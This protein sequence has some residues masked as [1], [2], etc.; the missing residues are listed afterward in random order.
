[1]RIEPVTANALADDATTLVEPLARASGLRLVIT[2]LPDD[3]ALATDS[4]K[5]RQI[6]V[7]LLSNAVKFTP[8]GEVSLRVTHNGTV[9][10]Y[11]VRDTGIGIA[12]EH[13][14]HIFEAFWQVERPST[15]RIG[16]TGLGL[17]VTRRLARLLGGD[18]AVE[19][20]FGKGSTFTVTLPM[21][22]ASLG[23]HD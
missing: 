7:N 23:P 17:S 13:L 9:V 12:P 11:E 6:L 21:H 16:G 4:G 8:E 22:S 3:V 18:V 19:S 14:D 1:V 15:R 2:A 10:Y 20:V 5:V